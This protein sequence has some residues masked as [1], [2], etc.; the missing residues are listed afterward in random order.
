MI[1]QIHIVQNLV[2][3]T[4][5]IFGIEDVIDPQNIHESAKG[6]GIPLTARPESIVEVLCHHPIGIGHRRIVK[7]AANDLAAR[8]R[9]GRPSARV[10]LCRPQHAVVAEPAEDILDFRSASGIRKKLM[11]RK[12]LIVM[13][14][15]CGRMQVVVKDQNRIVPQKQIKPYRLP[16]QLQSTQ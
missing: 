12:I 3:E 6:I 14:G 9:G 11:L 5:Q 7:V 16:V 15:N 10:R 2:I 13:H 1:R 8:S 4:L